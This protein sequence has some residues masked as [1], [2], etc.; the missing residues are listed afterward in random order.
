VE[1]W[2]TSGDKTDHPPFKAK[3]FDNFLHTIDQP[4]LFSRDFLP[5]FNLRALGTVKDEE[6]EKRCVHESCTA[7]K[8]GAKFR[9]LALS[10]VGSMKE[11]D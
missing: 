4:V 10:S 5:T 11:P 3:C 8:Q 1:R 6:W 2:W 7:E 9:I